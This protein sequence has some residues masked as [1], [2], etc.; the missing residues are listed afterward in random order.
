MT[1]EIKDLI[2]PLATAFLASFMTHSFALRKTRA[3]LLVKERSKAFAELHQ[4]PVEVLRYSRARFGEET[5]TEFMETIESLTES[6]KRS[7]L[8]HLLEFRAIMDR[9]FIY[10]PK[11]LQSRFPEF[12]DRLRTMCACELRCAQDPHE[13]INETS[14]K[15]RSLMALTAW[16]IE[17]ADKRNPLR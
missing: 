2:I 8:E 14:S 3:E 15:Y 4:K 17:E 5:G 13:S 12:E 16:L 7:P 6:E 9:N 11:T 1:I 10:Y